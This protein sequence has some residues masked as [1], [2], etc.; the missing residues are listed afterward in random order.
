[1]VALKDAVHINNLLWDLDRM[2]SG[3]RQSP[4]CQF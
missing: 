2:W 3:F 4:N 1:M